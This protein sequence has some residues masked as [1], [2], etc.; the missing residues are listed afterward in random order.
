MYPPAFNAISAAFPPSRVRSSRVACLICIAPTLPPSGRLSIP[1]LIALAI[2][3][4]SSAT[5]ISRVAAA[6]TP[7]DNIAPALAKIP[8][9]IAPAVMC[10]ALS[11]SV[12][13]YCWLFSATSLSAVPAAPIATCEPIR[14]A[15]VPCA[16]GINIDATVTGSITPAAILANV[17]SAPAS[18]STRRSSF[19]SSI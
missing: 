17:P 11:P 7:G 18:P 16:P 4:F 1:R 9:N 3:A 10:A 14:A 6:L 19:S 8:L 13:V 2:P 12:L 5:A 15:R